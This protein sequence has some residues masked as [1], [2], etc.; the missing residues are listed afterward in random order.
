[1]GLQRK[2]GEVI[3]EGQQF[4]IRG[5]VDEFRHSVN[6][7]GFWRPGM[8]IYVSHVRRKQIPLYAFPDGHKRTQ[9][10]RL[11]TQQPSKN[12]SSEEVTRKRKDEDTH[13]NQDDCQKRRKSLSPQSR[14]SVSPVI[15]NH[16]GHLS[17]AESDDV[18]EREGNSQ[19]F[20]VQVLVRNIIFLTFCPKVNLGFGCLM[21]RKPLKLFKPNRG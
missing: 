5:T 20:E 16:S 4:D 15:V 17:E 10:P 12:G 11:V 21:F 7:Y 6:M 1:M 3:Q 18:R 14:D 2:Q 9:Q 8:D 19:G 13:V